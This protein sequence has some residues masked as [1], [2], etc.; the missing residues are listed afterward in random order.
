L[1]WQYSLLNQLK[2][3]MELNYHIFDF[4][5]EDSPIHELIEKHKIKFMEFQKFYV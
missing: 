5:N 4:V 3:F 1:L 2:Y